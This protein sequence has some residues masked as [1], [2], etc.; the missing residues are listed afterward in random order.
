MTCKVICLH[1][2]YESEMG[3]M[4]EGPPPKAPK[5]QF[6]GMAFMFTAKGWF[7]LAYKHKH[8]PAYADAVRC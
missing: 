6:V 2:S 3:W 5:S 4:S 7:S 8:K 1:D